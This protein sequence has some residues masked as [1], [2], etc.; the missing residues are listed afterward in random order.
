MAAESKG[1]ASK[2]GIDMIFTDAPTLMTVVPLLYNIILSCHC[3]FNYVFYKII[4]SL[5]D[6]N[7]WSSGL[8]GNKT[9]NL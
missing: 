8:C 3:A 4:L 5:Y 6:Y 9:A 2:D 7:L 1:P